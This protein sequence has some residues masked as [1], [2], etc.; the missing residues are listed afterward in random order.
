MRPTARFCASTGP[1]ESSMP[2][3]G[4][5]RE[6]GLPPTALG[7]SLSS[8]VVCRVSRLVRL[9]SDA[10]TGM[11][12]GCG[13]S[14]SALLATLDHDGY[15]RKIQRAFS[16]S[17]SPAENPPYSGYSGNLPR[18]GIASGGAL[19]ALPTLERP[20][21]EIGS[22]SSANWPTPDARDHHGESL[23]AGLRRYLGGRGGLGCQTAVRL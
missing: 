11:P 19:G 13:P 9:V 10:A 15:W 7:L 1:K 14:S 12:G 23:A 3:S 20:T 22:S 2:M 4:R 21:G 6:G 8:A 16:A 18:W 5:S 17:G